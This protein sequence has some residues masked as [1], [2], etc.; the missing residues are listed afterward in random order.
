MRALLAVACIAALTACGS[1]SAPV[2]GTDRE[3]VAN[4]SGVI[5]ELER[6]VSLAG[7]GGDTLT[8]ARQALGDQSN[9]YTILVAYTDF[10][11]CSHMVSAAGTPTERFARVERTLASA[12]T[13]FERAAGLFTRAITRHNARDLLAA[14]R[15]TLDASPLLTRAKVELERA[16]QL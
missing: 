11:G 14:S 16:D 5:D 7:S 12:C 4:T 6:D 1:T 15:T 9:L 8:A 3:W 10:G 2:A 13:R